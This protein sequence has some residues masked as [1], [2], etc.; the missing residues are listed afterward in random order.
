VD[1]STQFKLPP[2]PPFS[3]N[4]N[5]IYFKQNLEVYQQS[6]NI[7]PEQKQI[8]RFWDDNPYV[9]RHNGHMMFADKKITPGGHWIGITSI[10]CKKS[11]ADAVKT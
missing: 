10:A 1:T 11:H 4:K 8:A 3:G 9:I 6:K 5:S 2:P 7:T